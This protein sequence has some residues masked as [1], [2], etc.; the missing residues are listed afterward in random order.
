MSGKPKL[1]LFVG[2]PGAGKTTAARILE[3]ATGAS[4]LWADH[5]RW[6]M[7]KQPNHSSEE[8][9]ALYKNLNDQTAQLLRSGTS[10]IFDTNFN[11]R[12]DRDYLREI[13]TENGAETVLIWLNTPLD[14]AHDRAVHSDTTRNGY[15]VNMTHDM[16]ENIVCKLEEPGKDE[17]P[18]K[19]DGTKL[20]VAAL[21]AQ[22]KS[23][24][25]P[26]ETPKAP[27]Q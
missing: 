20:D 27:A 26:N 15:T 22:F 9:Q 11:H 14:V 16:F 12:A 23:D 25:T 6:E 7:F 24:D 8:S 5:M 19:F 21:K 17:N 4:H 18:I 10:V 3:A 1:Y 2:Y 13:A